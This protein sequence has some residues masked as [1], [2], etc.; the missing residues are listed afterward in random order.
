MDNL[1]AVALPTQA[2]Y[3]TLVHWCYNTQYKWKE[4]YTL[5]E[6]LDN[7]EEYGENTCINTNEAV[8]AY[9]SRDWYEKDGYEI[10]SLDEFF[11]C[12]HASQAAPL[13]HT[14]PW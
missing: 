12:Y 8:L 14:W 6:A 1:F 2:E 10:I 5:H 11:I 9:C 3:N 4:T 7:W 13:P